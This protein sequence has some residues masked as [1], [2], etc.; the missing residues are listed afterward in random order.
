MKLS[1]ITLLLSLFLISCSEN[2]EMKTPESEVIAVVGDE[3]ITQD[4]LKAYLIANGIKNADKKT[5]TFALDTLINEVAMSN[6]SLK[7]KIAFTTEQ[8]NTFKYLQIRANAKNAELNYLANNEITA[9]D[10]QKEYDMASQQTSGLEFYVHHLLFKDEIQAIEILD[11]IKSPADYINQEKLYLQSNT[12]MKNVGEL[13]WV[14]LGQLPA[15]FKDKLLTTEIN[16]VVSEVVNS[17][18]GAHIIYLKET[19]ELQPPPIEEVKQGIIK[20]LTNQRISNFK[21]LAKAK[22]HVMIKDTSNN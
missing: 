14:T 13:G 15:D 9:N 20:S 17:S 22:A 6:I 3:K 21:Q 2:N 5:T 12:N 18:F 16:S 7:K 11:Q 1:I 4:L 19:R 10:I 8:L